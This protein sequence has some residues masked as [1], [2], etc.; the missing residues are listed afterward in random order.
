MTNDEQRKNMEEQIKNFQTNEEHYEM[1][2]SNMSKILFIR[3]KTLIASGFSDEQAFEIV[4][5][6]GMS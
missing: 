3:Y 6:R 4:K 1:L 5:S 2:M